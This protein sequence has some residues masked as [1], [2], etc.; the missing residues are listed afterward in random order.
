MQRNYR[1]NSNRKVA[2][3][4]ILPRMPR[5][6]NSNRFGNGRFPTAEELRQYLFDPSEDEKKRLKDGAS[7][8]FRHW[9][10]LLENENGGEYELLE[11]QTF[12]I[13]SQTLCR[14]VMVVGHIGSGK[15]QKVLTP[16]IASAI[17]NKDQSLVVLGTKGDEYDLVKKLCEKYRPGKRVVCVNL[18]DA[19]RTT[20]GWNPFACP[21]MRDRESEARKNGQILSE[22]NGVGERES[23]FWRQNASRLMAGI[24]LG[25]EREYGVATPVGLYQV[26]EAN[27]SVRDNFLEHACRQGVPFLA[28]FVAMRNS[29]NTSLQT[30]LVETQGDCQYLIDRNMAL[31]TS[32]NEFQFDML[33]DEPTVVVLETFQDD[34]MKTRPFI[35]MFFAQLFDAVSRRAKRSPGR[36]LPRPLS[37]FLDDFAAS[38]GRVPE[39][40]Q[41]LNML[42]S[43][44]ARVVIALQSLAQLEQFY[45][46]GEAKAIV[47]ACGSK[48]FL[49]QLSVADAQYAS[50]ESGG[51]TSALPRELDEERR[52]IGFARNDA[53]ERREYPTNRPDPTEF[54]RP[55]LFDTDV[56]YSPR[57]P[58]YGYAATIF[59]PD[60]RPFQAWLPAAWQLPELKDFLKT[61]GREDKDGEPDKPFDY[62]EPWKSETDESDWS[63]TPDYFELAEARAT[64]H[65]DRLLNRAEPKKP[66]ELKE[67]IKKFRT[68]LGYDDASTPAK[69][70]WNSFERGNASN[71]SLVWRT[72][73][74]LASRRA[75]ISEF[76]K[77]YTVSN[78]ADIYANLHY[79]EYSRILEKE[80]TSEREG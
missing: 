65:R 23:P 19:R 70:W 38:V 73:A 27:E 33:F 11:D 36:K 79:L 12:T 54:A 77:I 78:A 60:E 80:R 53:P 1:S 21:D 41:R 13:P 28:E 74:E 15:T 61:D 4:I 18:S 69:Q 43:M 64:A 34:V 59:L 50:A 37:L 26:L 75:T 20:M 51:T 71:L 62:L 14:N 56:K 8:S 31:V 52:S 44:D 63:P 7:I 67:A 24:I 10:L 30:I 48:F 66:K 45:A 2:N 42:R 3:G 58:E 6:S 76:F 22:V 39:C 55:L 35:N 47:S 46:P 25:L 32:R 16:A 72:C 68:I 29:S 57:H 9:S 40:A 5:H 49:P 17:A